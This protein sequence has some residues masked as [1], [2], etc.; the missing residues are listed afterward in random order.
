MP[1]A[2][3]RL[4]PARTAG[5]S[6]GI[7]QPVTRTVYQ[8][9]LRFTCYEIH[10]TSC[11]R[12]FSCRVLAQGYPYRVSDAV[13][14]QSSDAHRRLYTSV[15][16]LPGLGN[17]EMQ[18]IIHPFLVHTAA[19]HTHGLHHHPHIRG[20]HRQHDI[21]EIVRFAQTQILQTGFGHSLGRIAV[22]FNH[23]LIE[24]TMI[25][26]YPQSCTVFLAQLQQSREFFLHVR[27]AV[28]I[29]ARVYTHLFDMQG[30]LV[31]HFGVEMHVCDQGDVATRRSQPVMNLLQVFCFA[32]TLR[33]EPDNL[34]AR[35]DYAQCLLHAG[36]GIHRGHIQHR[37]Q[38]Y[39]IRTAD[40]NAACFYLAG[41]AAFVIYVYHNF[42][43]IVCAT[44]SIR[45]ELEPFTNMVLP[46]K[47]SLALVPDER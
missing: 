10:D 12:D 19:Q 27:D 37:L 2:V 14:Q 23:T 42:C 16:P 44:L 40:C 1:A 36:T 31:G 8:R 17:S 6:F 47:R 43:I 22:F 5:V 46:A 30:R 9:G 11:H 18:R 21:V 45:I 13:R 29:I 15:F 3:L 32:C 20:F 26:T 4:P 34:T 33:G 28:C 39:G 25:D 7:E 38:A 35:I 24:R 41:M